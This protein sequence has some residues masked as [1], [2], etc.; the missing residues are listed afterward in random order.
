MYSL[1]KSSYEDINTLLFVS[2]CL[3]S[4]YSSIIFEYSVLEKPMLFFAYDLESFSQ[5][6]RGFYEEYESYV[7]GKVVRDTKE[8]AAFI[9]SEF[10]DKECVKKFKR[11]S[12]SYLDGYSMERFLSHIFEA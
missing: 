11:E 3:I 1:I 12:F 6:G 8:V 4:D 7:P 10:Y 2:D 5:K 9:R